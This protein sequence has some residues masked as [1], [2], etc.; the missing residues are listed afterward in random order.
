MNKDKLQ[1]LFAA[2][3]RGSPDKVRQEGM[4]ALGLVLAD[5]HELNYQAKLIGI[6]SSRYEEVNE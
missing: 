3:A 2:I 6:F 5:I 1:P 4:A